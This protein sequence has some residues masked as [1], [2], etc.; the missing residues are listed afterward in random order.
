M[1]HGRPVRR[2]AGR[3]RR[4]GVAR[5][6]DGRTSRQHVQRPHQRGRHPPPRARRKDPR[7]ALQLRPAR[8]EVRCGQAAQGR[9]AGG[10]F[11][12]HRHHGELELHARHAGG[13]LHRAGVWLRGPAAEIH[14]TR[15]AR[16]PLESVHAP[17]LGTSEAAGRRTQVPPPLVARREASRGRQA[18]GADQVH[19]PG[20]RR[21]L[22]GPACARRGLSGEPAL[23][24]HGT[25]GSVGDG[26]VHRQRA[27][28]RARSHH[29]R[30]RPAAGGRGADGER[31]S[32]DAYVRVS[33]RQERSGCGRG[34]PRS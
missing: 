8:R 14:R 18:R 11:R 7:H 34:R 12:E 5:L 27:T 1:G 4:R 17:R 3:G 21:P 24:A 33:F 29:W 28:L 19:Q 9:R 22:E 13:D 26:E 23:P 31:R 25:S 30:Q 15:R 10:D 6:L 16:G 20:R 2:R 32:A